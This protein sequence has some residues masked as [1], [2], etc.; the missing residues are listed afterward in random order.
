MCERIHRRY[1]EAID[2]VLIN[3]GAWT[4]YSYGIR[5]ALAIL[6]CP[7]IEVHMS[8]IHAREAFRHHSVFAEIVKR[9]D[10]R[11]RRRQLPARRCAPRSS[12]VQ[13]PARARS[14]RMIS[15]TTTADRAH[16]LP[17]RD[18]Q[19]ADDLQ[20]VLRAGRHRRRR[21]ADGLSRPSD[22]PAVPAAAV[23]AEQHP[24]RADHDAA[25]GDDRRAARRGVARGADRRLVQ[26][27]PAHGGR[28]PAGRHVRRRRLR[29]RRAR[30]RAARVAGARVLVVG[31]GGVGSAIAASLAAAGVARARPVRHARRVGRR[32]SASGSRTHYPTLQVAT[33]SN[34]P[35]G[36][37]LVVN[38]TPLGMNDG[39]PLPIDVA[40][41]APRDLRRRGGD[42]ERDD[43]VPAGGAGARLPRSRWAPTCCSSRSRPT[44]SSSA[45]GTTTPD[46]LRAVAKI[47]Y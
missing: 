19:G 33:G 43:G 36:Y 7:V 24:R 13:A 21:R 16:R 46:E 29:A 47:R 31:A 34:D 4:H 44:S 18:V 38:A 40:R 42:E 41:I 15:G 23:H 14:A 12:A 1:G 8:N 2:A 39:D 11:L 35:A 26:R 3:A 27:R 6:T 28:P 17:D 32:R 30:A 10:L 5:D 45:S 22:Y 20:P 37:D 9:P 25:Q